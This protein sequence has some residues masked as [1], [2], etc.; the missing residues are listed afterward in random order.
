MDKSRSVGDH[1]QVSAILIIDLVTTSK[2][3]CLGNC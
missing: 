3:S 1:I 2:S